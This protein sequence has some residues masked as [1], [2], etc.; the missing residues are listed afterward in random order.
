MIRPWKKNNWKNKL[1]FCTATKS[2]E[3]IT[4]LRLP[5][6]D[7]KRVIEQDAGFV[8]LKL[9]PEGVPR[10]VDIR[11]EDLKHNFFLMTRSVDCKVLNFLKQAQ[12][13]RQQKGSMEQIGM[14]LEGRTGV[15]KSTALL[16]AV[17]WCRRNDW[18]VVYLPRLFDILNASSSLVLLQPGREKTDPWVDCLHVDRPAET[19][20]VLQNLLKAHPVQMSKIALKTNS[21]VREESKANNLCDLLQ[22]GVHSYNNYIRLEDVKAAGRVVTDVYLTLFEELKQVNEYPVALIL[23]EY[24]FVSGLSPFRDQVKRRFHASAFRMIWPLLSFE[25]LGK[26]LQHGLII[27]ATCRS[28]MPYKIRKKLVAQCSKFPLTVEQ[29]KDQTGEML[30]KELLPYTVHVESFSFDEVKRFLSLYEQC[31]FIRPCTDAEYAR[32]YLKCGGEID[33]LHRLCWTM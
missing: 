8:D 6:F 27:A 1:L 4:K 22:Y 9:V 15:G 10:V 33:K 23:D 26:S 25:Q 14:L 11:H 28:I 7:E 5:V 32:A 21:E 13:E 2:E 30:L 3:T 31:E 12:E 17:H 16:R 18:L 19:F 24:N 20:K 29:R